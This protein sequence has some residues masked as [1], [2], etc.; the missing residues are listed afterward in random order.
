MAL[1][2][3]I[4]PFPPMDGG[5]MAMAIAQRVSGGRISVNLERVIYFSGFVA[6]MALSHDERLA[7]GVVRVACGDYFL[8]LRESSLALHNDPRWLHTQNAKQSLVSTTGSILQKMGLI[9]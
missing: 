9:T 7:G 8:F 2:F 4:L 1:P 5:R 6:L 3:A